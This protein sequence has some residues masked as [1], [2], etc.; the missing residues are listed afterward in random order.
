MVINLRDVYRLLEA[1]DLG[2]RRFVKIFSEL[3]D[4]EFYAYDQFGKL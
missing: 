2:R 3:D 4:D 1:V